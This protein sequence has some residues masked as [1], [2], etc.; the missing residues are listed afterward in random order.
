MAKS[1]VNAL[2]I[3][4]EESP[5]GAKMPSADFHASAAETSYVLRLKWRMSEIPL[6]L[7]HATSLFLCLFS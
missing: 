7:A 5:V 4:F 2:R 3:H 1:G 6:G